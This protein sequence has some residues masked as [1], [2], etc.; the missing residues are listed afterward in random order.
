MI[1]ATTLGIRKDGSEVLLAAPSVP[2][3]KQKE[4]FRQL[5][6][7][8]G[9]T[10]NGKLHQVILFFSNGLPAKKR[11]FHERPNPAKPVAEGFATS[12]QGLARALEIPETQLKSARDAN[13][14]TFPKKEADGYSIEATQSWLDGLDTGE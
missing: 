14:E 7:T 2:V 8:G 13:A 10:E 4:L 5:A 3:H 9:E 6:T 11:M 1:K 12:L